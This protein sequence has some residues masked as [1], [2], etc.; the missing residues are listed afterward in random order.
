VHGFRA[1][2]YAAPRNDDRR[3]FL[4]LGQSIGVFAVIAYGIM[5]AAALASPETRGAS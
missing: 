2:R 5:I 3:N 4:P 1:R